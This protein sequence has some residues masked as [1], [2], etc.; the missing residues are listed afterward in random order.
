MEVN[1]NLSAAAVMLRF[2]RVCFISCEG[3]LN[4]GNGY[5]AI[6]RL[7]SPV[8]LVT[9][10][11]VTCP[12]RRRLVGARAG[13]DARVMSGVP[14]QMTIHRGVTQLWVSGPASPGG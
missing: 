1:T 5:G 8:A 6:A 13:R 3:V 12:G 14:S 2:T 10:C 11:P 7:S 9:T 4:F